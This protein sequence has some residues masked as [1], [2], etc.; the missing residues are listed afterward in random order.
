MD[1]FTLL[2]KSRCACVKLEDIDHRPLNGYADHCATFPN[3]R[4]NPRF[5]RAARAIESSESRKIA[6]LINRPAAALNPPH[7]SIIR[8]LENMRPRAS[9]LWPSARVTRH[10]TDV[11][12]SRA[13]LTGLS[14]LTIK[15]SN[16]QALNHAYLWILWTIKHTV[17]YRTC[18][19]TLY[20]F[21]SSVNRLGELTQVGD[22]GRFDRLDA[23]VRPAAAILLDLAELVDD[24]LPF[25]A[26]RMAARRSASF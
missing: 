18:I 2:R 21:V 1:C 6:P 14:I 11:P 24:I 8:P 20:S 15:D 5:G 23:K 10:A 16:S 26:A 7:E 17:T 19:H 12:L 22:V 3:E 4:I 9:K 25:K 13:H